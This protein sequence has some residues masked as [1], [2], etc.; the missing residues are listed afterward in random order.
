M[1][2]GWPRSPVIVPGNMVRFQWHAES[3]F[4][5]NPAGQKLGKDFLRV[6]F[7]SYGMFS[8]QLRHRRPG[9][10]LNVLFTDLNRI[11]L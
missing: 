10:V 3:Y 1:A 6:T 4:D 5:K 11:F 9:G 2:S 8:F 7:F